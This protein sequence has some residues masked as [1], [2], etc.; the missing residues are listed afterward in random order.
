M[1]REHGCHE[2]NT[3][4]TRR[5]IIMRQISIEDFNRLWQTAKDNGTCCLIDVRTPEEYAQGHVPGAQLICL[6]TLD[7]CVNE[8]PKDKD[9]YLICRSGARSASALKHLRDTHGFTR[10]TNVTG[11]TM[12]WINAGYAV[13]K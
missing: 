4:P 5:E 12:A 1:R 9:V 7:E 8:I 2:H 13:E 10:L 3:N 6:D 11:G